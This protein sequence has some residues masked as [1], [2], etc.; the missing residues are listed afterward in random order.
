M[1][2]ALFRFINGGIKNPLFDAVIPLFSDK[3]Y[4]ILPA[5]L[6]IAAALYFGGRR[7][8]FGL[9]ALALALLVADTGS[10]DFLKNLFN[11][12]RPY[13]ELEGVNV[14]RNGHWMVYDPAHY[15][16]DPRQSNSFPSSHAANA[17]A[18]VVALALIS[19]R[20]LWVSVPLALLVGFSRVYT[21]NHYP[22]DVLAGYAWGA[23]AALASWKMVFGLMGRFATERTASCLG[24]TIAPERRLFL[25][26]LALWTLANLWFV[27][28]RVFDLAGDE[29]QYWDWSRRLAFGYYSKPPLIAYLIRGLTTL[30]GHKEL[31]I[32]MG[33]VLLS[34]GTLALVYALTLR[35][36]KKEGAALLAAVT[37]LAMPSAW[38]GSVVMTIDAPLAFCW[39]LAMYAF[40]RAVNG[41]DRM[42]LYAGAA[43]GLGMLAKYTMGLLILSFVVY[44]LLADR[45]HLRTRGPYLALATAALLLSGVLYWNASN[46]WVSIKHTVAIGAGAKKTL[47]HAL[48]WASEF[49]LA[50]AGGIVSPVLFAFFAWALWSLR[51]RFTVDR[52]AAFLLTCFA[53][54]FGFYALVAFTRPPQANWPACAYLA[55]AP[56]FAWIWYERERSSRAWRWLRFGIVLGCLIGVAA[57]STDLVYLAGVPFAKADRPDRVQI[58]PFS[59]DPDKDPTSKLRGGRELGAA[60]SKYVTKDDPNQPFI[61]SDRYQLTAWAAFYTK[62]RPQTYCMNPGDRRYNQYDLWG[63]AEA[64]V[65]KDALFVTG[66]DATKAAAYADRLVT[67]GAFTRG[68]VLETVLVIRGRTIVKSFSISRLHGYTGLQALP[69]GVAKY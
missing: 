31:A 17:A 45:R 68:E 52:D 59:I 4:L 25:G 5:L 2:T 22:G 14:H 6:G 42:W 44:L 19:R 57:R 28:L 47:G 35:I 7:A 46:D 16:S 37:A 27:H 23:L 60:L 66:G 39:V 30:G 18:A 29:A 48:G 64:L 49:A 50:Q 10:E 53:G 24:K 33:A 21:G 15:A 40:H 9:V 51:R 13:A 69:S 55:A 54:L 65:G 41:E 56:A 38:A 43:L 67:S 62:G 58:G 11:E 32:R 20:T 3:D 8:R 26:M 61:M 36:S 34:S 1:N 63:G 12:R